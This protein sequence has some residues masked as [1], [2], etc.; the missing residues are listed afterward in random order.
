MIYKKQEALCDVMPKRLLP[1]V[2]WLFLLPSLA[3]LLLFYCVPFLFSFYYAILDN[4]NSKNIIGLKNFHDLLANDL[5]QR[6]ALHTVEFICLTV[7]LNA[8]LALA[9]ALV[10]H[11]MKRGR[12]AITVALTLPLVVPSGAVVFFW[13]AVFGENGVLVKDLLL[14][15]LDHAEVVRNQW[16]MGVSAALFL[17]KNIGYSVILFMS[18]L[19]WIPKGYYEIMSLEGAGK[20]SKFLNVT[21]VYLSPTAFIVLLMSVVNSFKVFKEIYM[22]YGAY[23]PQQLYMLQ[24]FMN[25]QF[26]ALN[27]QKLSSSAYIIFLAIGAVLLVV[28]KMQ[29]KLT[30][31]YE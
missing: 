26:A 3:G 22:L 5:F 7:P 25:N 24:H 14:M 27:L 21:F 29:K 16:H 31:M 8:A 6:A 20:I 2:Y 17:W 9:M 10:L 4:M 30:D 19:N 18:G 23:P 1:S 28:F 13:S 12:S 15:G 11:N